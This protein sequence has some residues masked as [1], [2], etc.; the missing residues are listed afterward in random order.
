MCFA[1]GIAI[2]VLDSFEKKRKNFD[3]LLT[4]GGG[5]CQVVSEEV[6]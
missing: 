5:K 4:F 3:F 2:V 6:M 1:W